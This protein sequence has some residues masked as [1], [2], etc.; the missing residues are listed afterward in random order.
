MAEPTNDA[1][2]NADQPPPDASSARPRI[3]DDARIRQLVADLYQPLD[4]PARRAGR[5]QESDDERA[6][7]EARELE[8]A[9]AAAQRA[10]KVRPAL[11][12][13]KAAAM[14]LSTGAMSLTA[15]TT[16]FAAEHKASTQHARVGKRQSPDHLRASERLK[17]A[18]IEEEGVR[19]TVYRDV[20]GYPTVGVGHLVRPGD[21]L[22]LGDRISETQARAFLDADLKSAEEAAREL[23][24]GLP[25]HQHEFDALVDLVY[26]VGPGNVSQEQSPNLNQ[27]IARGEYERI[28]AELEYTH[29]GGSYAR[30]LDHRSE[31]RTQMF[32]QASYHNPRLAGRVDA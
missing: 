18:L 28:A 13:R 12:T 22:A 20:A 27:A 21:G 1:A 25:V 30:G 29:A 11:S 10:F 31:R 23:L 8:R 17:Q 16:P 5:Q 6:R 4:H 19:H 3:S 7:R 32:R 26:N 2:A 9:R 14:L 15:F 24:A